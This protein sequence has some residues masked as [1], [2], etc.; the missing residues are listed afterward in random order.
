VYYFSNFVISTLQILDPPLMTHLTFN[1]FS[2]RY[3]WRL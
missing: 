1:S 3:K 2:L